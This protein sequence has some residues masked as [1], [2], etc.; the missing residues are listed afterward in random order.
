ML[1]MFVW[2][3]VLVLIILINLFR[4]P[5]IHSPFWVGL[6]DLDSSN[7]RWNRKFAVSCKKNFVSKVLVQIMI[8]FLRITKKRSIFERCTI[9]VNETQAVKV[10]IRIHNFCK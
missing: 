5:H 8:D 4:F 3:S 10:N 6:S 9:L 7:T 1:A 2:F